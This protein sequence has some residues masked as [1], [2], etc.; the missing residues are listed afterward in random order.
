M[1][2]IADIHYAGELA[3]CPGCGDFQI[4]KSVE[5][6]IAA[7]GRKPHETLLVSGIG[8]AAKLPHYVRVNGFNGL[9][10]RALPAA[11][12]AKVAN[13]ALDVIVASGDGDLYGE[14]GNHFI[15]T[16]RRNIDI[17]VVAHN[18]GV[19][20]LTKGQA[21]PTADMGFVSP[22]QPHGV[23]MTPLNPV[24]LAISLGAAFVARS[25]SKD[26]DFTAAL[27]VEAVKTPG[28]A[29]IDVLQPCV[30]FNKV[31]TYQWYGERAYKLDATHNPADLG[32]ALAKAAEWGERI[33]L[34][35]LYKNPRATYMDHQRAPGSPPLCRAAPAPEQVEA[36]AREFC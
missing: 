32:A 5:K 23:I 6:A 24:T 27:I 14:G 29:L 3:W 20:G 7:L 13:E 36:L 25:F 16:V 10:G 35:V 31:N 34:G 21:S 11:F 19:Y 17:T 18:N 33:P 4:L 12:G 22:T 8:Q 1:A 26:I 15:H 28:F 9:H 30:S 2:D